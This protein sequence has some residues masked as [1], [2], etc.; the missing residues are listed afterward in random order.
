MVG[1]YKSYFRNVKR[2]GKVIFDHSITL[3]FCAGNW[4][5]AAKNCIHLRMPGV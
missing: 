2:K 4:R 5:A 3:N 1:T